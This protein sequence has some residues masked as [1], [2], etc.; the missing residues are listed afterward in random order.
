MSARHL[1]RR[2]VLRM[3]GVF[4]GGEV[5]LTNLGASP[6]RARSEN[7]YRS[8]AIVVGSVMAVEADSNQI[9]IRS[10]VRSEGFVDIV[11]SSRTVFLR[12]RPAA[13]SDFLTGDKIAVFGSRQGQSLFAATA[14]QPAYEAMFVDVEWPLPERDITIRT[15]RG[16]LL[17]PNGVLKVGETDPAL[18]GDLT[19]VQAT[20]R[21][22]PATNRYVAALIGNGGHHS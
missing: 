4:V 6:A 15:E 20:V 17:I 19:R 12:D 5:V 18:V 13:I 7:R 8:D 10:A 2:E 9:A 14:V 21:H 3:M 1:D 22:E 16:D 11:C